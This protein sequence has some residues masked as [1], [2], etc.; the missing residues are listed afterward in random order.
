MK[1]EV[2]RWFAQALNDF[3]IA[4]T[5]F[6][7]KKFSHSS[8]FC[9][10]SAEK[11]LKALLLELESELVKTHDLVLLARRLGAPEEIIGLCK[12]LAP[13]YVESRYPDLGEIAFKKFTEKE[14]KNDL[15]NA[16]L[17]IN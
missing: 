3:D 7:L 12:E 9:Q 16:E 1:E 15:K 10:Q 11:A 6:G 2:K 17:I 4:K 5:L 14:T 8:F 13:V